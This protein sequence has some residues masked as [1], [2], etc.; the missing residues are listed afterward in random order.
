MPDKPAHTETFPIQ[1][2]RGAA[3]HPLRVPW[4]VAELAY[5]MYTGRHGKGQSLERLAER[6]GFAPS[7]MDEFVPDWRE[8]CEKRLG[9]FVIV[10]EMDCD[11]GG[12]ADVVAA[13]DDESRADARVEELETER[14]RKPRLYK[15]PT[16]WRVVELELNKDVR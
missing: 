5:S 13:Y 6:G 12:G 9:L 10:Q 16:S 4:E 14:D 15:Y 2:E 8:R 3:A 1:S 7:E 11:R